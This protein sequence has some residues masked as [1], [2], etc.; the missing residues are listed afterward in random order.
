MFEEGPLRSAFAVLFMWLRSALCL[1]LFQLLL[2]FLP[3]S[4]VHRDIPT[5]QFT[6]VIRRCVRLQQHGTQMR[7]KMENR[8]LIGFVAQISVPHF[9][10]IRVYVCVI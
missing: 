7:E 3:F 6:G 5:G 4:L 8:R 1:R 10:P 9:L 2:I